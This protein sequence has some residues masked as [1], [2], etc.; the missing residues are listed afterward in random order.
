[1]NGP[2]A[3]GPQR[4]VVRTMVPLSGPGFRF[5]AQVPTDALLVGV[6]GPDVAP[7]AP[8]GATGLMPGAMV[9]LSPTKYPT[10]PSRQFALVGE[11]DQE[12]ADS[13]GPVG[14]FVQPTP[15]GGMVIVIVEVS[16]R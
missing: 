3:G 13:I 1:M 11:N 4:Y 2:A 5:Y 14:C 10:G 16:P 8:R 9:F 6:I 7:T 12:P 15:Y